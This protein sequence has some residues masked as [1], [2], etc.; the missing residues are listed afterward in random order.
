M[1]TVTQ[2]CIRPAVFHSLMMH[3]STDEPLVMVHVPCGYAFQAS[4]INVVSGEWVRDAQITLTNETTLYFAASRHAGWYYI[5][6]WSDQLQRYGCS[7]FQGK[8]GATRC[9]HKHLVEQ[10][11]LTAI[12]E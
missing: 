1:Q 2:P 10:V 3:L 4:Y 8:Q 12:A 9:S 5:L 11:Q 6:Q 7:C